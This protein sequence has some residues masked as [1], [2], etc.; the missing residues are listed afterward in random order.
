MGEK[1]INKDKVAGI[2]IS[3]LEGR[4]EKSILE[5][6]SSPLDN[7]IEEVV[8]ERRDEIKK[9]YRDMLDEVFLNNL[10]IKEEI[11]EEFKRKIAKNLVGKLEG[12][13]EK[14][15]NV[16]RQDPTLRSKMIVALE[17]IINNNEG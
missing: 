5:S 9:L 1:L 10:D 14:A 17:K 4:L 8:E 11:K 16:L 13:V 2:I 3:L 7:I 12:Q 15:V 6:Y